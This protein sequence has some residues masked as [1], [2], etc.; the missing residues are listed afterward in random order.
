MLRSNRFKRAECFIDDPY[1]M[2]NP[3]GGEGWGRLLTD[4]G[5][6]PGLVYLYSWCLVT[7]EAFHKEVGELFEGL[8]AAGEL[9]VM[10][11][12]MKKYSRGLGKCEDLT[13]YGQFGQH[14]WAHLKD[15]LR[16]TVAC[17]TPDALLRAY[18]LLDAPSARFPVK[19]V[20]QR[21][22]ASTHDVL[23]VIHFHGLLCE[24]Q[25]HMR[26]VLELKKLSHVAYNIVRSNAARLESLHLENVIAFPHD[27]KQR[28]VGVQGVKVP[29][30]HFL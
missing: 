4:H 7:S 26:P 24:V 17:A 20:K 15:V 22:L 1:I 16:L 5:Q 18:R 13:E 11:A 2:S 14:A 8:A 19:M 23:C 3:A 28:R 6:F 27:P 10:H 25:F 12:T 30:N 9:K 29:V 21:L